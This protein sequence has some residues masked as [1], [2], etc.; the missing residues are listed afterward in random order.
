MRGVTSRGIFD[1]GMQ[2]KTL[3]SS[4]AQDAEKTKQNWPKTSQILL[5]ISKS[6]IEDAKGQ[7]VDAE[8]TELKLY[9]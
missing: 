1:G 9:R 6:Y 3:S 5:S 4:Y 2:E 8:L 7:D